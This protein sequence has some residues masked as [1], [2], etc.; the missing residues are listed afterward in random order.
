[1]KNVFSGK[2]YVRSYR[3]QLVG[4]VRQTL[5][6][7]MGTVGF[8]LLIAC[9]NVANLFLLRAEGRTRETAV[10]IALGAGRGRIIRYVVA[11]SLVL[12]LAGGAAGVL[13]SRTSAPGCW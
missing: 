9:S 10:R 4:D 1:M 13:C 6:V 7:L 11:E 3:E 5:L 8:V 12:A 2:A